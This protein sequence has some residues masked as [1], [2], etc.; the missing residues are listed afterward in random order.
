MRELVREKR[1]LHI[2]MHICIEAGFHPTQLDTVGWYRDDGVRA[3]IVSFQH[4]IQYSVSN[5]FKMSILGDYLELS[6]R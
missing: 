1:R 5:F 3:T 2:D 6:S 4:Y